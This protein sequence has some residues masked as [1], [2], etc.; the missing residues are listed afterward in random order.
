MQIW[1]VLGLE[2]LLL[3]TN[4]LTGLPESICNLN[5]DWDGF[6]QGVSVVPYFGC[7]GNL[8]CDSSEIPDCVEDSANFEISLDAA[9]YLF[10]VVHEQVCDEILLGDVNLDEF[11]NVLDVVTLVQ[12]IIGGSDLS[13]GSLIAADINQDDGVNVLDVVTL[14]NQIID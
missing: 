3:H 13:D 12:Y 5:L 10:S 4:Q 8:L 1:N 7:G 11:I 14:V 9:Y 6:T 2:Q